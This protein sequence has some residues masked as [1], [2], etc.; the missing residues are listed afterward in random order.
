MKSKR[1]QGLPMN[2]IVIAAIVLVVMVVLIMIFSGSMGKWLE[3]LKTAKKTE[4]NE[5]TNNKGTPAE[6]VSKESFN[7]ECGS[8]SHRVYATFATPRPEY[9]C[10]VPDDE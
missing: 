7:G 9:V 3:D 6:W 5:F 10:C 4:C 1:G 2:T 8:G